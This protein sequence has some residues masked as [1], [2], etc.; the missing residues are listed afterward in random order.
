[1]KKIKNDKVPPN[2]DIEILHSDRMVSILCVWDPT[3]PFVHLNGR[4]VISGPVQGLC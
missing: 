4:K 3:P 1:M 2:K